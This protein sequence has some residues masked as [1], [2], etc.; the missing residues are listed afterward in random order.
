LITVSEN[1][2]AVLGV[3]TFAGL[4]GRAWIDFWSASDSRAGIR[5]AL[6]AARAGR[7]CRF[8]AVLNAGAAPTWWDIAVTPIDGADG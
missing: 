5:D 3:E 6:D 4:V 8:Q 1:G 7:P 2:P